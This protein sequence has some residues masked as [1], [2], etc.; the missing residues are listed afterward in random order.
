MQIGLEAAVKAVAG[1]V[2]V[3]ITVGGLSWTAASTRVQPVESR[4][5]A[6]E[7][8]HQQDDK[9]IIE[10]LIAAKNAEQY[11]EFN[12]RA[13]RR[14]LISGG[15]YVPMPDRVVG[16]DGGTPIYKDSRDE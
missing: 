7:Q 15:E 8:H 13:M 10:A 2:G 1:I 9:M 6:I 4:V 12:A 5:N 14:I 3:I 16:M 11:G